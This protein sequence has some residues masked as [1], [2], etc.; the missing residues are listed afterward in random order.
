MNELNELI[1]MR[2]I[3]HPRSWG[4]KSSRLMSVM[5]R[6]TSALREGLE[7]S[8]MLSLASDGRMLR[9]V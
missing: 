1:G 5:L 7:K 2:H 3:G 4:L 6:E 8:V 9:I